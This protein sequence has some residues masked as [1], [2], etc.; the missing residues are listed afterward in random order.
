VIKPISSVA[1]YYE[2]VFIIEVVAGSVWSAMYLRDS[3]P[4]MTSLC[5]IYPNVMNLFMFLRNSL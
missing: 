1:E 5:D 2:N 3:V 4:C